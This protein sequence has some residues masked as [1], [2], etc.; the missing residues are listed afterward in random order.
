MQYL[1]AGARANAGAKSGRY[2]Y[3]VK[4]VETLSP[5]EGE[6]WMKNKE[7]QRQVVRVG[8][9]TKGSSLLLGDDDEGAF[10]FDTCLGKFQSGAGVQS[11]N[12]L[13]APRDVVVGVVLNLDAKSPNA[14]TVSVFKN[15][16][17]CSQPM[18]IP[19]RLRGKA[20]FP[21]VSFRNVSLQVNFGPEPLKPLSFKCRCFQDAALEDVIVSKVA[22]AEDG[23][24]EVLFPVG[25]PDEGAFEWVDSFLEKNPDYVE[26]SDRK[27]LDWATRSGLRRKGSSQSND[28]PKFGFDLPMMDDFS[29][30]R[31]LNAVASVVPRNYVVMELKQNLLAED[32]KTILKRF[33]SFSFKRI[34]RVVMGEPSQEHKKL[35]KAKL[36]KDKQQ[37][38]DTAWRAQKVEKERLKI[39]E[40]RRK[41]VEAKKRADEEKKKIEEA[42]TKADGD[43]HDVDGNAGDAV[44]QKKME[45]VE[46]EIETEQK[47][48]LQENE[49]EE[50]APP[51]VTLTEEE[52]AQKHF[53]GLLPD[54]AA[55][56]V[57]KHFMNFSIPD[58]SEGF[59]DVKFEWDDEKASADYLR[60]MILEKKRTSRIEDLQPGEWF[61]AQQ[62]EW[63][64]KT[65]EWQAKQAE[66]K[67][68]PGAKKALGD[69]DLPVDVFSVE[70]VSSVGGGG[71]LCLSF[72]N[73]D[74][75][76][77]T[78]RWQLYTLAEAFRRD[79]NDS[80]RT[81][82][83]ATHLPFYYSK[84]FKTA[85]NPTLYGHETLQAALGMVKDTVK[86]DDDFLVTELSTEKAENLDFFVKLAEENRRQRQ[87]RL[88]AGDETARLKLSPILWG[89]SVAK[90]P[91]PPK[92]QETKTPP[93]KAVA[94]T[95]SAAKLPAGQVAPK[96]PTPPAPPA[97]PSAEAAKTVA[98]PTKGGKSEKAS[99]K[100]AEKGGKGAKN[101]K[102]SKGDKGWSDGYGKA[103]HGKNGY[104]KDGY[105]KDAYAKGGYGK[106]SYG[107][108]GYSKGGHG[109]GNGKKG[110]Y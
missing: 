95:T 68:K 44:E 19:D 81:H 67:S 76:L 79:V 63:S 25:L 56:V 92:P 21:H 88:D 32:R 13:K 66:A 55:H 82:I 33:P 61:K 77:A 16:V 101:D 104:G 46:T 80:D 102:G 40:A 69:D 15:G 48:P 28:K 11:S 37:K 96:P 91:V 70:D 85:L 5:Y 22:H 93:Q 23:K 7:S 52:E 31:I 39:V 2:L 97:P 43:A 90:S 71:P 58:K 94:S 98:P 59:D 62:A 89:A 74:W 51:Q 24:H 87:R 105:G 100:G 64:K 20:L 57:D 73:E 36:L 34:A 3:E 106:D 41:E 53:K 14:N 26:L 6:V 60:Q 38:A 103:S 47:E 86:L 54:V 72:E 9:S 65:K 4:V 35:V 42:P 50:S 108:G 83:P 10:Y 1:V 78:L 49:P 8:F 99:S 18:A 109:K 29:A 84:Y 45:N 17:R 110:W 107:K 27:I 75:A 12:A 30:R